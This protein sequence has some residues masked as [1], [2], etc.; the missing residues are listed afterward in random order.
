MDT[1]QKLTR[2]EYGNGFVDKAYTKAAEDGFVT[3]ES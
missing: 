1:T 3:S 2:S